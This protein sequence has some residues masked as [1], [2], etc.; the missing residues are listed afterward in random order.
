MYQNSV[1][2]LISV[3]NK[4]IIIIM[5]TIISLARAYHII[6]LAAEAWASK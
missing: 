6:D 2:A 3:C 4:I 1:L 5:K